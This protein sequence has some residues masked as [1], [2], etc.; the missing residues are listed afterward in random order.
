MSLN[1]IHWNIVG[2]HCQW[3]HVLSELFLSSIHT[4]FRFEL[5]SS[6]RL[7]AVLFC[8][9]PPD[10]FYLFLF[11]LTTSNIF[12]RSIL[13]WLFIICQDVFFCR[14]FHFHIDTTTFK[15]NLLNVHRLLYISYCTSAR[16]FSFAH[17][18][19][20]EERLCDGTKKSCKLQNITANI[21]WVSFPPERKRK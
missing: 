7:D 3:Y 15:K 2:N 9:S 16:S 10:Y 12:I 20:W 19:H 13:A 5:F 21:T 4:Q 18:L 8:F 6:L 11:N 1:Q 17:L 14:L